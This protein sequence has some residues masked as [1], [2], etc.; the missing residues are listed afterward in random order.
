VKQQVRVK[1]EL[2]RSAYFSRATEP[3]SDSTMPDTYTLAQGGLQTD[4]SNT[5]DG[6]I[7]ALERIRSHADPGGADP[8]SSS[9]RGTQHTLRSLTDLTAYL[10]AQTY[11]VPVKYMPA[12]G[13]P[14][15]TLGAAEEEVRKEI[16]SLK[17]MLLNRCVQV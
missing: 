10:T 5:V 3:E 12:Y 2:M 15:R 4:T 9:Q 7:E 17:G 8:S 11:E 14:Q 16:R 1:K 6:L 13:R